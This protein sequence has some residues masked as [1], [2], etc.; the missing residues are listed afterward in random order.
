M[1]V[2]AAAEAD[3]DGNSETAAR[4]QAVAAEIEPAFRW[5]MEHDHAAALRLVAALETYWENSGQVDFGRRLTEEACEAFIVAAVSDS[6]VAAAIP[7]ALL[8]ASELAF[9]QGDQEQAKKRGWD[10]IR[11]AILVDDRATAAQ[12]HVNLS[13]VAY[14]D[15]D[16]PEIERH[17]RKA[18][19]LAPSDTV[20]NRGALYMLAWAAHTAGDLDEA[21]RRFQQS[22]DYRREHGTRLS[23]AVEIANLGDLAVE[24]GQLAKAA[25]LMADSLRASVEAD[26]VYMLVNAMPSFAVL[27][28]RAGFEE[29]AA[30]L[31]GAGKA[32]EASS[33]LIPD[34]NSSIDDAVAAARERLGGGRYDALRAEGEALSSDA[35]VRLAFDVGARIAAKSA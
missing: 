9:R 1:A 12:A 5:F 28:V 20:V 25:A 31:V 26:S 11:A 35:A 23:V 30:R 32:L 21:E 8:G 15:G 22:L 33:G 17:A 13:R 10:C 6:A 18:L 29:D 7:R 19:E 27:A 3:R 4:L 16:A 24:R 14:R 2:L 34:P